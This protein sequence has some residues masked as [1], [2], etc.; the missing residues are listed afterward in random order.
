[1]MSS[2]TLYYVIDPMCS[3]CWAF[4]PE[5][6]K[7]RA[8]LPQDVGVRYVM[9]GLA[10]DSDEPMPAQMRDYLQN[11]WRTISVVASGA[12]SLQLPGCS[13]FERTPSKLP[14]RR[15]PRGPVW[16]KKPFLRSP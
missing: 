4:K 14:S 13:R 11:V 2:P 1:M 7:V 8:G 12:I 3:W 10:P 9:G 15:P 5:W 16:K 6:E